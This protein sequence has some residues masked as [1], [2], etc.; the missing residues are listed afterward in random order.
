MR[1]VREAYLNNPCTFMAKNHVGVLVVLIGTTE[2]RVGDLDENLIGAEI[3]GCGRLNNLAFFRAFEDCEL[4]H[5]CW[6]WYRL[7]R[8]RETR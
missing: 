4:N 3:L 5:G 1:E 7:C 8:R 6:L 2:T